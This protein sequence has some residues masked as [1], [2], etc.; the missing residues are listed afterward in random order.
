MNFDQSVI[1]S[2]L[3]SKEYMFLYIVSISFSILKDSIQVFLR[4]DEAKFFEWI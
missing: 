1:N 4:W 3:I 2:S